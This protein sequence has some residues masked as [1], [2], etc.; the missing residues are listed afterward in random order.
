MKTRN[1]HLRKYCR[2]VRNWLPCSGKQKK[3]ILN[4]IQSMVAS[5]LE[6]N[7]TA[8][9]TA[10]EQRFGVP[11]Q[12][13]SAYVDEMDSQESLRHMRIKRRILSIAVTCVVLITVVWISFTAA[14]FVDHHKAGNGYI[15]VEI[16]TIEETEE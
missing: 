9:Y 13:A 11:Q 14:A 4:S 5:Y 1:P 6:E 2:R 12:I 3:Q 15:E 16:V 10:I 7:Q 8:D